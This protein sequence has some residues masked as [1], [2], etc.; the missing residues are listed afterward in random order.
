[1]ENW[2]E[3]YK[4]KEI[5]PDWLPRIIKAGSRV[6]IGSGCSESVVLTEQLIQNKYRFADCH[7]IHF[8]TLSD[9]KF[10]D[11]RE[12]TLFRHHALFIGEKLRDAVNDG[13]VDY[14]GNFWAGSV[15]YEE[16][17]PTGILYCLTKD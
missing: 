17:L 1:M 6:F 2:R 12:P 9:N 7:F 10:F 3:K 13:K 16:N 11:D 5:K 4:P 15:S 8:L 14:L